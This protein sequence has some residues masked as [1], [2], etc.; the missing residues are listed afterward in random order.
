MNI[1]EYAWICLNKRNS[2]YAS[3]PK[4]AKILNMPKI[5]IWQ[6]SEYSSVTQRSE[7]AIICLDRDLSISRVLYMPEFW[8]WQ[9]SEYLSV[10]QC[11]EYTIIKLKMPALDVNMPEYVWIYD[12]RHGSEY[13]SYNA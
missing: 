11:S 10:I 4:Y 3:G 5:W 2:E 13:V 9:G 8:I 6:G 7:Y 12:N 1:P